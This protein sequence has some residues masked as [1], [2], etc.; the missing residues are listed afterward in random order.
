MP[1]ETPQSALREAWPVL[2]PVVRK[3]GL[4]ISA[5]IG[6]TF[7]LLPIGAALT[8]LAALAA[9]PIAVLAIS[10]ISRRM[11]SR[12]A[13]VLQF[14]YVLV[15]LIAIG[16]AVPYVV[17][18]FE[19]RLFSELMTLGLVAMSLDLMMGFIGL[20]SFAHA[21]LAGIAS[22]G[23]AVLIIKL[24][25]HPW[26]AIA[27]AIALGT[28]ATTCLGM[29]S[30][31]VRDIYFGIITLV[32]GTIFFVIANTWVSVTAGEDGLTIS[33]PVLS[34]FGLFKVDTGDIN[35]FWYLT[36]ATV[37]GSYILLRTLLRSPIGLVFRG[38]MD[39]EER[40]SY[41]GYNVNKYKILNTAISGFFVSIAGVLTVLRNGIVGPEQMD[42]LHSGEIVIWAVIGGLGTLVGPLL[43][44]GFVGYVTNFLANH[45]DRSILII[46]LVFVVTMLIAPKGIV[47]TIIEQWRSERNDS[48][49]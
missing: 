47:G 4:P 43:G 2:R 19:I 37:L 8:F 35:S 24:G 29:F 1:H 18:L 7:W 28:A 17:G 16:I 22:Y 42:G 5:L 3:I 12:I 11:K 48:E 14:R 10:R 6:V 32:F 44:A 21:A 38:I 49:D 33:L 13:S 15:V 36:F 26:L 9:V 27:G 30:V 39:N 31:R 20:A 34:I 40:A 46:G 23:V 41:L 25:F 45:T